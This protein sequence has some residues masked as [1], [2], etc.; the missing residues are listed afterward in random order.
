MKLTSK[1]NYKKE[2]ILEES[3]ACIES[4][5]DAFDMPYR[6][7]N[8]NLCLQ[9]Q[10]SCWKHLLRIIFLIY[11]NNFEVK[12]IKVNVSN[13]KVDVGDINFCSLS[14]KAYQKHQMWIQCM[15]HFLL[16]FVPFYN[17]LWMWVSSVKITKLQELL[18]KN[19]KKTQ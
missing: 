15:L 13:M 19:K 18:E 14:C 16:E 7:A 12:Y 10:L 6:K 17:L 1:A 3:E 5:F 11:L 8:K 4:T 2:Q 9:H